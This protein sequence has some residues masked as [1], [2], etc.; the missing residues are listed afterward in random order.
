MKTE[1]SDKSAN[2]VN[3]A[4]TTY[5]PPNPELIDIYNPTSHNIGN[6][7]KTLTFSQHV[8]STKSSRIHSNYFPA[9]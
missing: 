4:P 6:A 8:S 5:V 7:S 9:P 1:T 2:T 3:C